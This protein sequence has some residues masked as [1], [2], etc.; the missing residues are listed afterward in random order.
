[1]GRVAEVFKAKTLDKLE[2]TTAIGHVRYSTSG[3]SLLANAQPISIHSHFGE[4]ALGHNGNLVNVGALREDLE[5]SGSVFQSTTDSE[6]ILHL[7]ARSQRVDLVDGLIEALWQVKGAYPLVMLTEEMMIGV[8]DPQG[9]RPL[10]IG[11]LDGATVL[12]SET[13]ALDLI[14]AT[15]EREVE[16]GEMV[17]LSS[18][19]LTSYKPF[20]RKP[21]RFCVF[22]YIYFARPDS[23]IMDRSVHEARKELGRRLAVEQP[24]TADLVV[25]VPDSG[26]FAAMGYAEASNIPFDFALIRNHYVGRTFIE[27]R[28]SIRDF[29]VKLKLNPVREMIDG[30]RVVLI[31]DSI[32]RGTTS[33]KIVRMVRQAGAREVHLRISC[34]PTVSPC[35]YG[36]DTPNRE[37]LIAARNSVEEIA[38]YIEADSLGYLTVEGMEDAIGLSDRPFCNACFTEDY[39]VGIAEP[40]QLRLFAKEQR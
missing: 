3:D 11:T 39:P 2:G 37:E 6:V 40:A 16:P 4:I 27:P 9:F 22:E 20:T 34:P 12:T 31:D 23:I 19:G 7:L 15:L 24:A 29:G 28:Q 18:K 38:R 14:D 26:V 10:S 1:M 36:I 25:P 13:C 5:H 32:V 33:R 8:R 35:Y 21:P 17:I 30:K